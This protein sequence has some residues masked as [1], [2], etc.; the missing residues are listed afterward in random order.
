M[1]TAFLFAVTADS[2]FFSSGIGKLIQNLASVVAILV[3]VFGIATTAKSVIGG[4]RSG[5]FRGLIGAILIAGFLFNL[6]L[7]PTMGDWA[8]KAVTAAKDT[9]TKPFE[10]SPS[11]GSNGT[12]SGN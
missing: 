8:G 7:I 10:D 9:F 12:S 5:A 2:A 3:I 6:S 1:Q 11:G 4:S